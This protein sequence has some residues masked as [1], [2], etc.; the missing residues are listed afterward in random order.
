MRERSVIV[1][2]FVK[3]NKNLGFFII[4]HDVNATCSVFS[5]LLNDN[6]GPFIYGIA[7][8]IFFELK[9]SNTFIITS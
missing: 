9:H 5:C 6:Q 2:E 8:N 4:W 3:L 7:K 1:L